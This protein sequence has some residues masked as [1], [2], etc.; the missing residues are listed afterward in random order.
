[1]SG[2]LNVGPTQLLELGESRIAVRKLSDE[3][4]EGASRSAEARRHG[5]ACAS[6]G[7]QVGAFAA[8]Y[9]CV[10]CMD[11]CEEQSQRQIATRTLKGLWQLD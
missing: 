3:Q 2:G 7:G 1:M 4:L 10:A 11:I 8:Y 5:Y 9:R 6:E